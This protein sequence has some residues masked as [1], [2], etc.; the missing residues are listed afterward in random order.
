M[1]FKLTCIFSMSTIDCK[2]FIL[3]IL[4]LL[5]TGPTLYSIIIRNNNVCT[6]SA[7]DLAWG[8]IKCNEGNILSHFFLLVFMVYLP[9]KPLDVVNIAF[10]FI[11]F[12][13]F[14]FFFTGLMPM[15]VWEEHHDPQAEKNKHLFEEWPS[16]NLSYI[17]QTGLYL[18]KCWTIFRLEKTKKYI[19]CGW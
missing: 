5:E 2:F 7:H 4:C 12:F 16:F 3:E 19:I 1:V 17:V 13:N 15:L 18:I 8:N 10:L 11:N 14:V 6:S 9:I